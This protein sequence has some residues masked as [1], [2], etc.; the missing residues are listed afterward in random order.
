LINKALRDI[1]N[2]LIYGGAFIGLCAACITALSL[3]INAKENNYY[4]YSLW[5]GVCTACLYCGHRVIGLK[6]MAHIKTSERF[7]VIRKYEQHIWVYFYLWICLAAFLFF[8]FGSIQLVISMMPGGF[9]ALGYVLPFLFG[10]KRFRDLGWTKILMIGWSWAWLTSFVPLYFLANEPIQMALIMTVERMLFIIAITI[11][12]EV[13]DIHVDRSVGLMTLPE[14][15]GRKG[16]NQFIWGCCIGIVLL[17]YIASYHYF[18]EA[19]FVTMVIISLC[20]LLVYRYSFRTQNDYFFG[21][22][23]DGLMIL[24]LLVYVGVSQFL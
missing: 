1:V 20:T 18:N 10:K 21:G 7:N 8:T 16:T 13:R 12:F 2:L 6:K 3:E 5:I 11:P 14:K 15:F 19:Y 17:S 4:M 23:I 24:A 22:L 9:I